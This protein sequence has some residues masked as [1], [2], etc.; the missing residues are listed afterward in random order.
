MVLTRLCGCAG[1]SAP[2]FFPFNKASF[3]AAHFIRLKIYVITT[4][5]VQVK[6]FG[7][8]CKYMYINICSITRVKF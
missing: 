6:D 1:W 7:E 4:G 8:K 2:L 5:L 3:L